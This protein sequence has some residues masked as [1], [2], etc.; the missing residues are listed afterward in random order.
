MRGSLLST[1]F[2]LRRFQQQFYPIPVHFTS[3][4]HDRFMLIDGVV[5][6]VGASFK[7]LGKKLF[8]FSR[9][10]DFTAED[11]LTKLR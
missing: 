10:N 4:A 8:A 9:L 11:V 3:K 7:D 2:V 5:Y 1:W 6:H